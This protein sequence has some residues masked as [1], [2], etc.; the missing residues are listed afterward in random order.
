MTRLSV[1]ERRE[2]LDLFCFGEI[3]KHRAR[4]R[5]PRTSAPELL[6]GR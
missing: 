2:E 1:G 4:C 3:V 6:I 5:G